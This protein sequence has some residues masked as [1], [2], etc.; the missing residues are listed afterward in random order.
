MGA[1]AF[2]PFGV[3]VSIGV[4]APTSTAANFGN[5][6]EGAIVYSGTSFN[7]TSTTLVGFTAGTGMSVSVTTGDLNVTTSAGS[8][9]FNS[10]TSLLLN[11]LKFGASNEISMYYDGTAFVII[12]AVGGSGTI[13]G[14]VIGTSSA[15]GASS[16][17]GSIRLYRIGLFGSDLSSTTAINCVVSG[18]LRTA[19]NFILTATSGTVS[20]PLVCNFIN[21]STAASMLNANTLEN[22]LKTATHTSGSAGATVMQSSLLNISS[23]TDASIVLANATDNRFFFGGI[24]IA[25]TAKGVGGTHTGAGVKIYNTG[26]FQKK[27]TAYTGVALQVDVGSYWGNDV[28][29]E[30]D[31]KLIF[32][33]TETD[34][35]ANVTVT[36]GTTSMAWVSASSTLR[37]IISGTTAW[38]YTTTL[39]KSEIPLGVLV[40]ATSG[41]S[42]TYGKVGGVILSTTTGVG[43]VL[44]GEDDLITFSVPA[45]SLNTD[46]DSLEFEFSG[47]YAANVNTKQVKIK[48]GATTMLDTTALA[49]NTGNWFCWGRI[50]RTGAATQRFYVEFS[51]DNALLV[52][53]AK[54]GTA[55]ETLSGAITLKATGTATLTDDI[56]NET[57]HV[58]WHPNE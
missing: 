34:G 23:G 27:N 16:P 2:T 7:F 17:D 15:S 26:I 49:I 19:L 41:G 12:P 44:T 24:K 58:R 5:S 3:A 29:L 50:I 37:T 1:P 8:I 43:N 10:N 35:T 54:T 57:L 33:N 21:A 13:G 48:F 18:S 42:I 40:G 11:V 20:A 38:N 32:D 6:S 14:V 30:N 25:L 9:I 4:P 28:C 46:G 31:T 53:I 45:A 55:A 36:K 56:R 52:A 39:N 47:S 51:T 22:T